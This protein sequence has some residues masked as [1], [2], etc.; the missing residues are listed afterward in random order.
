VIFPGLAA[1]FRGRSTKNSRPKV[2]IDRI[3]QSSSTPV[4]STVNDHDY[5]SL[6]SALNQAVEILN[7]NRTPDPAFIAA[8]DTLKQS[9]AMI[10]QA[11]IRPAVGESSGKVERAA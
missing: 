9:R 11:V 10:E 5:N 6:F 3:I 2:G 4:K 8:Y 1:R 7:R